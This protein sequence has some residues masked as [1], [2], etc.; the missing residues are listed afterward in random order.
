MSAGWSVGLVEIPT[1]ALK[2]LL[3]L[4]HKGEL[5]FP[6]DMTELTRIGLQANATELLGTLR[7]LEENGVR[8]V[9]V[10]VLAER[11]SR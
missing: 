10:A 5:R 1:D 9:L 6:L 7:G 2:L 11:Q 3:R 8:A 4:V